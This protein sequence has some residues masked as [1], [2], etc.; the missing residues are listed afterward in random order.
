MLLKKS[1]F[2]C[3]PSGTVYLVPDSSQYF[4]DQLVEVNH[5]DACHA[6]EI[7]LDHMGEPLVVAGEE[8][9]LAS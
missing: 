9:S 3:L 7:L 4:L 2:S 1:A 6:L 8:H 5:V